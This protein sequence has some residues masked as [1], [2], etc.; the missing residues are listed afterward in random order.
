MLFS[1]KAVVNFIW[2]MLMKSSTKRSTSQEIPTSLYFSS[3][4]QEDEEVYNF[5]TL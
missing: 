3:K 2:G 1:K 4:R 5:F